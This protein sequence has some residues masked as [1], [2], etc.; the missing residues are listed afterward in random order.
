M[1]KSLFVLEFFGIFF[2]NTFFSRK[3]IKIVDE[4]FLKFISCVWRI[5]LK[6]FQNDSDSLKVR[7]LK[8]KIFLELFQ[9]DLPV[10]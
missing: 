4:I 7:E 6:R 5:D 9:K 1:K 10:T 3:K 2:S 8:D